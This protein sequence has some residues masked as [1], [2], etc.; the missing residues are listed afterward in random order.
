MAR[1]VLPSTA[2][3]QSG[4]EQIGAGERAGGLGV[5]KGERGKRVRHVKL[6]MKERLGRKAGKK[7]WD[8]LGGKRA[9]VGGSLKRL[10]YFSNVIVVNVMV[11]TYKRNSWEKRVEERAPRAGPVEALLA[12]LRVRKSEIE[13]GI[14]CYRDLDWQYLRAF[15]DTKGKVVVNITRNVFDLQ[16]VQQSTVQHRTV[17]YNVHTRIATLPPF[18]RRPV[19]LILHGR[20]ISARHRV[21]KIVGFRRL[22][23]GF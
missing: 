18:P 21:K 4:E 7:G 22:L 14:N 9:A 20:L 8:E 2:W 12:M 11:I 17:P 1:E 10:G 13:S 6:Y 23:P 15:P 19:P 3:K 16:L 5:G